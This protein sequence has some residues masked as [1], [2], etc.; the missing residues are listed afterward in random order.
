MKIRKDIYAFLIVLG[1]FCLLV[2][3]C[4]RWTSNAG[5]DQTGK[6][7][8]GAHY[9]TWYPK[10]F[11]QGCLRAR[12]VPPQ[13]PSLG[14]YESMRPEVIEQHIAWASRYGIDFF[15][16]DWWPRKEGR[17]DQ[18]SES[19]LKAKNI[20]DIKFCIFYETQGL[21]F[22][23]TLGTTVFDEDKTKQFID[24]MLG[25]ADKFFDHPSYLRV[26]DRPVI[27]LYLTRTLSGHYRSALVELRRRMLE[28]GHRPFIV[29]DE[30]FW[31][32]SPAVE[33]G[34]RPH[35]LVEEPQ[36]RRAELF[37]AITAYNM[38]ENG[39]KSQSGYG[40]QS[41]FIEDVVRKY[42]EYALAISDSGVHLVPMI[43]P[44]YNDRGVR[45]SV[46]HY[47]IPRQWEEG[48]AEGSFFAECFD[49]IAFPMVDPNLNMIMITSWNEWNEDTGIEPLAAAP[50]TTNDQSR[51]RIAYTQGYD[52]R[53]HGLTYLEVVR[54]KVVAV[55]GRVVDR[56]GAPVHGVEV[57]AEGVSAKTDIDGYYRLSRLNLHEGPHE[58]TVSG[59]GKRQVSVNSTSTVTAVD[60]VI[61]RVE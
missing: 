50:V 31:K 44:G 56:G 3:L 4:Y 21:G 33:P 61:D 43:I 5:R 55:S 60:F 30:I 32:V 11:E 39:K 9:Y 41:T 59:T 46:N 51:S 47:A 7:L 52:Y 37:D 10:H 8:V 48:A 57:R 18:F 24:D 22:D 35:P 36:V 16:V 2:F 25:I 34:E 40:S 6:Y 14:V 53:G 13:R 17:N 42:E 19:L 49:R 27:M 23:T 45:L 54:D 29:G 1:V 12:L 15:A 28:K 38:Y 58:V 20:A 26:A